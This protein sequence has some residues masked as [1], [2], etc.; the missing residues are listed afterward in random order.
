MSQIFKSSQSSPPPPT[1][2]TS[3]VTDD[4]T[5]NAAA[6]IININGGPGIEVIADPNLSNNILI[7]LSQTAPAYTNVTG[8]ITYVVT[9]TDYFISVDY[10]LGSVV[11]QLPNTTTQYR[12]FTVKDRIGD[13]SDPDF[14]I[15]ITTVGGVVLIDG[16]TVYEFDEDFESTDILWNGTSYEIY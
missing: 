16:V 3:F 13:A 14:S 10:F 15:S 11:I 7:S 6:N 4:G 8:P 1:V 2:A 12:I 5:V 9:D